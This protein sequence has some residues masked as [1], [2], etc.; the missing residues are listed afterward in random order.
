MLSF[1]VWG[2]S[3]DSAVFHIIIQEHAQGYSNDSNET[4]RSDQK[5]VKNV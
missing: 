5:P 4:K 1:I 2:P 3:G